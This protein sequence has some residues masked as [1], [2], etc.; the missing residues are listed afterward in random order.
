MCSL[1]WKQPSL[2]SVSRH[3]SD[4]FNLQEGDHLA[5]LGIGM[6]LLIK[7]NLNNRTGERNLD[8]SG[9]GQGQVPGSCEYVNELS[10]SIKC[11]GFLG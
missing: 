4:D 8:S 11:G 1:A 3:T 7:R 2:C 6:R 9:S 10:G 5:D